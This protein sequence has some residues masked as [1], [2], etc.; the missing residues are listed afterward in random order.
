VLVHIHFYILYVLAK[1][2]KYTGKY[3][4]VYVRISYVYVCNY[5]NMQLTSLSYCYFYTL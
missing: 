3:F 1:L 4:F 5:K 2:N